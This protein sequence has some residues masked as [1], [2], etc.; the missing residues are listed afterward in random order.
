[1]AEIRL[2]CATR[3]AGQRPACNALWGTEHREGAGV[4]SPYEAEL[5]ECGGGI[6]G[7]VR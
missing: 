7:V 4:Y 3:D 6:F 5:V 1:M 2:E